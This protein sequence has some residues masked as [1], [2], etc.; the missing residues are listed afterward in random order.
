MRD[1]YRAHASAV[2]IDE[3]AESLCLMES[4]KSEEKT[5]APTGESS[6]PFE[7]SVYN[8]MACPTIV[9]AKSSAVFQRRNKNVSLRET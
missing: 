7:P 1:W 2:K 4:P 8:E 9:E 5:A 3:L 6:F